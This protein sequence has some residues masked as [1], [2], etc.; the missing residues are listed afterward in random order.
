[1]HNLVPKNSTATRRLFLRNSACGIGTMA[2]ATLLAADSRSTVSERSDPLTPRAPHFAPRAKRVIFLF[3]AGG[4]SHL[5]LVDYK[6]LLNELAGQPLPAS[7][8]EPITAMGEKGAPLLAAPRTCSGSL[9]SHKPCS[10]R[11]PRS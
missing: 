8:K 7:F 6:P 2:L 11:A 9:T 5:D 4:P 3:M 1:M 10:T